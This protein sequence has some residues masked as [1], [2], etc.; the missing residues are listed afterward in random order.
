MPVPSDSARMNFSDQLRAMASDLIQ[1]KV[2]GFHIADALTEYVDEIMR[3]LYLEVVN[4]LNTEGPDD[5]ALAAVGGY[6]RREMMPNSDIDIM[7]LSGNESG[8]TE[9]AVRAILYRLWDRGL[10]ISHSFR[11]LQGCVE[12]AMKDLQ[13]RTAMMD[14]RFISGSKA[15]FDEFRR[16]CYPKILFRGASEFTA[17]VLAGI[18][19]RHKES[20]ES[21]Y[22]IEPDVKE[23]KGGLRDIHAISWLAKSEFKITSSAD[24]GEFLPGR[25][26]RDFMAAHNFLLKM[27]ACIHICSS[28]KNDTLSADIH[29]DVASMLGFI[30]TNRFF[31]SE[32]MMRAFYLRSKTVSDSLTKITGLCGR[33]RFFFPHYFAVKKLNG[34]FYLSKNEIIVK[35]PGI[36]R[37]TG[38]IMEAFRI[39]SETGRMFSLQLEE[40]LKGSAFSID[41]EGRA[42]RE[43][44]FNFR[45]TLRGNRVYETLRKMHDIS[46]LDRFVPEFGRIRHL[47]ILEAFHRYTVDE[48]TL[49][50]IRNIEN[51]GKN[52]QGSLGYLAAILAKVNREALFAALLF[53]DIG[54]GVSRK[55]E[56]TGYLIIRNILERLLF[57]QDDRQM[58]EFLVRNHI[59]LAKFALT[60]DID[61]PETVIRLAEIVRNETNLDMLYIMTY[62]DMSAVNPFFWN[63]WKASLLHELYNRTL[64]H[65]QGVGHE[66]LSLP[67]PGT[68]DFA[69]RMSDRYLLSNTAEEIS[70][71]YALAGLAAGEGI[72]SMIVEKSGA[73]ELIAVSC[74][75]QGLFPI[76]VGILSKRR[77]NIVR[78]RLFGGKGDLIVCKIVVSNW[79][80]IFWDGI[81]EDIKEDLKRAGLSGRPV[82]YLE[83]FSDRTNSHMKRAGRLIEID[84]E[85][86]ENRTIL[87]VM[88]P[89][90]I[91][92]LYD[93]AVRL[94]TNKI[95]ILSAMI[96]TD[97]GMANDVFYLQKA[98]QRLSA[99]DCVNILNALLTVGPKT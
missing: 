19:R 97:D 50:S 74:G 25:Q 63:E 86:I 16:D 37:D 89:D 13:T 84:N 39:F 92:L 7:L 24:Y 73:A 85:T 61:A 56:E 4:T 27:R 80:D 21:L 77:L 31:A 99:E 79:K 36:F 98:G 3:S 41:R 49:I 95:D 40:T 29:D 6:G 67:D 9:D 82:S 5:L 59:V 70:R 96:N 58:I 32:V 72:A 75:I 28:R 10:N 76:A 43:A 94:Q 90:H 12:D 88:L 46:V 20:G 33:R 87:E 48:H 18:E 91:G 15:V 65:L 47:V 93:I 60:R 62:A 45:E 52:R 38:K 2:D 81:E 30:N 17:A 14:C 78:A 54:K 34:D 71:D 26:F 8:A 35:E 23:C 57:D 22:L 1:Q 68:A 44:I 11:T 51:L 69:G 42:S 64:D 83:T 53:H 55:H 66:Q